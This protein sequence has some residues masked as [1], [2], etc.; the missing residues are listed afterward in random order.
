MLVNTVAKT[1]KIFVRNKTQ[2]HKARLGVVTFN[3]QMMAQRAVL[4]TV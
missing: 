4:Q 1:Y 3:T 2:G